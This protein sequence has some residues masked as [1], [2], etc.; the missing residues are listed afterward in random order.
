[1]VTRYN[2]AHFKLLVNGVTR[3]PEG[4]GVYHALLRATERFLGREIS[5]KY[6]GFIPFDESAPQAVLR[7]QPVLTLYPAAPASIAFLRLARRL[8]ELPPAGRIDG[9][10][11]FF[12]RRFLGYQ[13]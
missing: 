5:L 11:K 4:E 10:I 7:Q 8:R 9:S 6:L 2:Q 12:G 1:M 3:P 13:F